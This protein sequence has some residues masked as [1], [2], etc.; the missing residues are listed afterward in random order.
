MLLV[1]IHP[2]GRIPPFMPTVFVVPIVKQLPGQLITSGSIVD[3]LSSPMT[4]VGS[5]KNFITALVERLGGLGVMSDPLQIWRKS[6][7]MILKRNTRLVS[8][9]KFYPP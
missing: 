4:N 3:R 6:I 5:G 2:N 1:L 9:P 7:K 8:S